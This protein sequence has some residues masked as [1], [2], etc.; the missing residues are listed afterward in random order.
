MSA[1]RKRTGRK[2]KNG[3]HI[4]VGDVVTARERRD[5]TLHRGVV[6]WHPVYE[7]YFV[8]HGIDYISLFLMD[9]LEVE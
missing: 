4:K 5:K 8:R 9:E 6:T 7:D 1:K 3:V 2:D